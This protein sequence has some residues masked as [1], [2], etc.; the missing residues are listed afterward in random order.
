MVD[1]LPG[2]SEF[3]ASFTFGYVEMYDYVQNN[4]HLPE[5]L[6]FLFH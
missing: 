6:G 5:V 4:R 2:H 3:F 1:K